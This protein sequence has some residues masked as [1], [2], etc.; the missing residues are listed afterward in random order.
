[1]GIVSIPLLV[2]AGIE[3]P[4]AVGVCLV[5][6]FVQ[7]SINCWGHRSELPWRDA[8]EIVGLRLIGMPFGIYGLRLISDSGQD[9][10]RQL[11]G[12]GLLLVL[13]VQQR[14]E[15]A[16]MA[17]ITSRPSTF[18]VGVS[19]GFLAGLIGMG[20]PPLVIWTMAQGWPTLRQRGFLW[21]SFLLMVPLQL[22]MMAIAFGREWM[23]QVA[24]GLLVIPVVV[25]M[26]WWGAKW[27]GRLSRQRLRVAMQ[28]FLLLIACR[29]IAEP[30]WGR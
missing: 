6:V 7:S 4:V 24:I 22:L 21:S 18:L 2:F 14:S 20:G 19:S 16:S 12:V 1:M 11:L 15:A 25:M 27:G 13:L 30:W 23:Q 17:W 3:L 9:L 26:A 29:L 10:T 8:V 28:F 5:N